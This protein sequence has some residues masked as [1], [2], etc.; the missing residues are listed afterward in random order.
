[1]LKAQDRQRAL[2]LLGGRDRFIGGA[3]EDQFIFAGDAIL[4][5]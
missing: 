1:M 2:P 5:Y 3:K 4:K